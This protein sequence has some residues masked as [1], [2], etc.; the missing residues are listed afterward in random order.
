MD[1]DVSLLHLED[2]GTQTG[3]M[4]A[5]ILSIGVHLEPLKQNECLPSLVY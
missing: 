3:G 1:T 4:K 2:F 5:F